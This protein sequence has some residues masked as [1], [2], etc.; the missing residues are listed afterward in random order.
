MKH[1]EIIKR[2]SIGVVI[3]MASL[4]TYKFISWNSWKVKEALQ[5]KS[6]ILKEPGAVNFSLKKDNIVLFHKSFEF[7]SRG[8]Y[9]IVNHFDISP[10]VN[11]DQKLSSMVELNNRTIFPGVLYRYKTLYI[12]DCE[13]NYLV[14]TPKDFGIENISQL[15]ETLPAIIKEITKEQ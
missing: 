14:F 4:L 6:N 2:I 10:Y 7:N 15:E 8:H 3:C 1:K 9:Y 11:S 12:I 5:L 13:R